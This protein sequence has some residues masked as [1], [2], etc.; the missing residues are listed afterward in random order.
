MSPPA[1][2][3]QAWHAVG[4]PHSGAKVRREPTCEKTWTENWTNPVRCWRKAGY[5]VINRRQVHD[6]VPRQGD[7]HPPHRL[8]L[9]RRLHLGAALRQGQGVRADGRGDPAHHGRPR[10]GGLGRLRRD[11][12]A[13]RGRAAHE[14]LR[15][16]RDLERAVGPLF[17]GSGPGGRADRRRLH[18]AR[19][20][21]EQ[22]RGA[23]SGGIRRAAG[24]TS[25]ASIGAVGRIARAGT[26]P[27][28]R[29]TRSTGL[30]IETAM[31]TPA[32]HG[33]RSEPTGGCDRA[34][35]RGLPGRA[36]RLFPAPGLAT[37]PG[38][39]AGRRRWRRR[40]GLRAPRVF[41]QSVAAR[42]GA[43]G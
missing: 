22:P 38:T 20:V 4:V 18:P 19:D 15:E 14:P 21:P 41:A 7:P 37:L 3:A 10:G 34:R 6:S 11:A 5:G 39:A 29:R 26:R 36:A 1:D 27:S 35:R 23:A 28:A 2:T 8:A 25:A 40:R 13:G 33:R 30:A 12:A 42:A 9:A 43:R 24:L 16:R 32:R 31:A 17:R